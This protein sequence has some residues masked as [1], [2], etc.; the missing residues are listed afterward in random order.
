M[1]RGYL[2]LAVRGAIE[3]LSRSRAKGSH[4]TDS[5]GQQMTRKEALSS[6]MDELAK[7]HECI[8]LSGG[9]GNPCRNSEKCPGFNYGAGGGCPGHPIEK[10]SEQ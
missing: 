4:Y 1:N 3:E 6:L 5:N 8:P 10:G 9:C 2:F 7:G